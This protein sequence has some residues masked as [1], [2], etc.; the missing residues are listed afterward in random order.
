MILDISNLY[1]ITSLQSILEDLPGQPDSASRTG[2][3]ARETRRTHVIC[4]FLTIALPANCTRPDDP[5]A[6]KMQASIHPSESDCDQI[7]ARIAHTIFVDPLKLR[8]Y[9]KMSLLRWEKKM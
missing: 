3:Y 2:L 9:T 5:L 8:P 6:V 7:A 4:P 1:P